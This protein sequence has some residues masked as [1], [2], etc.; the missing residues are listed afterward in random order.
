MAAYFHATLAGSGGAPNGGT[1]WGD[2]FSW[3]ELVAH[4]EGVTALPDNRYFVK[5]DTYN[6]TGAA[7]ALNSARSGT[8]ALP[9][10]MTGVKAATTNVGAAIVLSDWATGDDRPFMTNGA[11]GFSFRD[12][13]HIL[14]MRGTSTHATNGFRADTSAL[15]FNCKSQNT[16]GAGGS[17]FGNFGSGRSR[18]ISCDGVSDNGIAFELDRAD[19]VLFGSY[20]HDS[21]VGVELG[22]SGVMQYSIVDT[23]ATG[24]DLVT[25][26]L[27]RIINNTLYGAAAVGSVGI[28]SA[29]NAS[30][31]LALNNIIDSWDIGAEWGAE[32]LS[33]WFDYNNWSNNT[34][35][36]TFVTKGLNALALD[37]QFR[38]AAA[39]D[40]RIGMNLR[41]RGLPSLSAGGLLT[42]FVDVGAVQRRSAVIG[43]SGGKQ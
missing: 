11:L 7:T 22:L 35:D 3:P 25:G 8:A 28:S 17:A 15:L 33:N 4:A 30:G 1:N 18:V 24:L 31:I 32:Q 41:S 27:H 38:D 23:C 26:G 37:P 34:P 20:A 39:G 36:T 14:N 10:W 5:D 6:S 40:F 19:C 16:R 42:N 29:V 2:A 9:I 13:W 43:K 12:F 21:V